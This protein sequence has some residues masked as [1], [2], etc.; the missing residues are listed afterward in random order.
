MASFESRQEAKNVWSIFLIDPEMIKIIETKYVWNIVWKN[1]FILQDP[2][3]SKERG[4][5]HG[6]NVFFEENLSHCAARVS[7]ILS[8]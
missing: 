4:R 5:E 7:V 2:R 3:V 6:I 1:Y 8:P